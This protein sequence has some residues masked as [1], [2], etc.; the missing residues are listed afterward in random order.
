M[1]RPILDEGV[2][3]TTQKLQLF[4]WTSGPPRDGLLMNFLPRH[5]AGLP[6]L[7]LWI[8]STS[9]CQAGQAPVPP[10][11]SP[12]NFPSP[13]HEPNLFRTVCSALPKFP[14]ICDLHHQLAY[15]NTAGIEKAFLRY[16]S[17]F[18]DRNRSTIGVIIAKQLEAPSSATDVFK[19][20]EYTCLFE[21]E[22]NQVDAEVVSG[23]VTN[24]KTFYK[25]YT[26]K[27]YERWFGTTESCGKTNLL[28]LV[29]VDG[30]IND[31]RKIPY[32]RIHTGSSRLRSSLSNIQSEVNNALVQGWPMAKVIEDL[33]DDVGY[34]LKEFYELNGE[35]RDHSVPIWARHV[36]L[37]CLAL[38]VTA[39]LVEWYIVRRKLGVQKS[40]SI[41]IASGKSKTH[42]MF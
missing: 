37:L 34:A 36:F 42:L 18:T 25:V 27:V 17:L 2:V 11:Y 15:T 4:I 9:F 28:A 23:I 40:G 31:A 3:L 39:L 32:V 6:A 1:W 38:V 7:L 21:N 10:I 35:T 12:C 33:I 16:H 8:S 13:L 14:F 20:A 22:C 24:V 30:L 26:W 41:K 29:V 5:G 19:N